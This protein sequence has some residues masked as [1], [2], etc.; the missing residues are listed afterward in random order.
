M[1]AATASRQLTGWI[2]VFSQDLQRFWQKE[3]WTRGDLYALNIHA[4]RVL[5]P[6]GVILWREP[7]ALGTMIM[8]VSPPAAPIT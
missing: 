5:W 8:A 3:T 7:N 2:E 6:S 4:E 1:G